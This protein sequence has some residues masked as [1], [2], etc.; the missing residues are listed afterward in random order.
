[1]NILRVTKLS[2]IFLIIVLVTGTFT[3]ISPSFIK[4]QAQTEPEYGYDN[5]YNSEYYP[6]VYES[7]D[8]MS[9]D[10][11]PDIVVPID[12]PT[13]QE[14]I[15]AADE[16]DV[17]KVLPSTYTEQLNIAKS[18]TIIGS[19]A[20][21]TIIETPL[22]LEDLDINVIGRPYIVEV[23]TE[24]EVT[25]KGFTIKGLED[26]TCDVLFGV[27][28]LGDATLKLDSAII[29]DCTFAG[30]VVG[31]SLTSGN[32]QIGH[33][34]IT[35]TVI[36]DYQ[37]FGAYADG[38]GSTLTMSYNKIV[39]SN[40][41]AFDTDE[42]EI[43]P[44]LI[45]IYFTNDAKATIT[46][47]EVSGNICILPDICGPDW[48]NQFQAAGIGFCNKSFL[49]STS[50]N[51]PINL[52]QENPNER[53]TYINGTLT[54]G[55]FIAPMIDVQQENSNEIGSFMPIRTI[56]DLNTNIAVKAGAGSIIFNNYLSNN[57]VGLGMTGEQSG[58]CIIDHNKLT[59]NRFFGIVIADGEHT[60]SNTK[61]F[62]GNIGVAAIATNAN[63]VATLDH[64]KIVDAEIPVHALSSGDLTAS[65]NVVS[66]YF[67]AP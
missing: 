39:G 33:T 64:V 12:F 14:A 18:L 55:P 23:N 22:P 24:A 44:N 57:D 21:S 47:N 50:D 46:H 19:G 32:S 11:Y 7:N 6:P 29:K 48:F 20:K 34:A 54:N 1:M 60:I 25:M 9:K 61:I 66:P 35:N 4:V 30:I 51:L 5:N 38:S 26:A 59:D 42:I 31:I 53:C 3:S 16:G 28:V 36:T 45:G 37:K 41:E 62:G 40:Y 49:S 63:T 17:I 67:F 2:T 27:T 15:D 56:I 65:V 43:S 10:P 8:Y 52:Q 13:I 58:C